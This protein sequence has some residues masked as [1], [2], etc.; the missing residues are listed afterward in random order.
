MGRLEGT[1]HRQLPLDLVEGS[2]ALAGLQWTGDALIRD[3]L[4]DLHLGLVERRRGRFPVA[5]LPGED[6]V[7]V[8]ALAMSAVGLALDI[9]AQL[10]AIRT[11]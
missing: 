9:L 3:Q 10:P 6:V 4:P 8:L 5:D 2:D 11:S 1:P 7:V